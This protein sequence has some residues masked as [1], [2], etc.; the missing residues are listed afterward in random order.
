MG[1]GRLMCEINSA[2]QVQAR[3][4]GIAE[5]GTAAARLSQTVAH[6]A[7]GEAPTGGPTLAPR[8]AA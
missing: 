2:S 1:H 7:K 3:Q 8:G 6:Y 4:L 5:R